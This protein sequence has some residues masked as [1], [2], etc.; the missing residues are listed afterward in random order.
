MSGYTLLAF[1]EILGG[2]SKHCFDYDKSGT[3]PQILRQGL[4][5]FFFLRR[6]AKSDARLRSASVAGGSSSIGSKGTMTTGL[7]NV[8]GTTSESREPGTVRKV[9]LTSFSFF[10]FFVVFV[11]LDDFPQARLISNMH[12][13]KPLF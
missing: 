1:V 12:V 11:R 10:L 4:A 2:S 5:D 8:L 7:V 9:T 13:S 6:R 3:R